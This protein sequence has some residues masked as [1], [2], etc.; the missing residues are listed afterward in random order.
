M[1]WKEAKNTHNSLTQWFCFT[2][3]LILGQ[4][5]IPTASLKQRAYSTGKAPKVK[6]HPHAFI[7][8]AGPHPSPGFNNEVRVSSGEKK[9]NQ[10]LWSSSKTSLLSCLLAVPHGTTMFMRWCLI[11]SS[12][13]H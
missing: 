3:G 8:D 13:S 4:Q 6:V 9:K 11:G 12:S 10:V 7:P 5:G 2:R 1:N